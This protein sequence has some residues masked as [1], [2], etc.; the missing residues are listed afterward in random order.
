MFLDLKD[1]L[2]L[3]NRII[4][5]EAELADNLDTSLLNTDCEMLDKLTE[6]SKTL[7]V[8]STH[9]IGMI[10]TRSTQVNESAVNTIETI[11]G[12]SLSGKPLDA[13]PKDKPKFTERVSNAVKIV[14]EKAKE[15]I[16]KITLAIKRYFYSK[17]SGVKKAIEYNKVLFSLIQAND[18]ALSKD[19]VIELPAKS[20]FLILDPTDPKSEVLMPTSQFDTLLS[21]FNDRLTAGSNF[22]QRLVSICDSVDLSKL[23]EGMTFADHSGAFFADVQEYIIDLVA[24]MNIAVNKTD[25]GYVNTT[26]DGRLVAKKIVDFK[27]DDVLVTMYTNVGIRKTS[28]WKAEAMLKVLTSCASPLE[29]FDATYNGL[30]DEKANDVQMAFNRLLDRV[31]ASTHNEAKQYVSWINKYSRMIKEQDKMLLDRL[32]QIILN[33]HEVCKI[34]YDSIG[35][36]NSK[37]KK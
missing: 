13:E 3:P 17:K 28:S 22:R 8:L 11:L 33:I 14:V 19:L 30:F 18:K 32:I 1:L 21:H 37:S 7:E 4:E 12:Y 10:E 25:Q 9:L 36:T 2:E 23:E 16:A 24:F 15:L 5:M 31:A 27:L 35:V 29:T 26:R 6:Q 20:E 34:T